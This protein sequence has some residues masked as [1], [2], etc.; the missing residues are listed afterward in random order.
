MGLYVGDSG[1]TKWLNTV[2]FE[3]PESLHL[4]N[5]VKILKIGCIET[6]DYKK[7]I[8][9]FSLKESDF[10]SAIFF[11]DW[12][13]NYI[14]IKANMT[15][16]YNGRSFQAMGVWPKSVGYTDHIDYRAMSVTFSVDYFIL[17]QNNIPSYNNQLEESEE[18]KILKEINIWLQDP[19]HY[20]EL[21]A[22]GKVRYL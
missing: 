17:D 13:Q 18:E 8:M 9:S 20:E 11:T 6:H 4:K 12:V 7:V 1:V 10:H 15:I 22:E 21:K 16:N 5:F 14:G 19:Y 3:V 2:T